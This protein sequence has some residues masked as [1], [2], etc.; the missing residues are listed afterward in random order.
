[1]NGTIRSA[2]A[3]VVAGGLCIGLA[4]P[5][6]AA[7]PSP[8]MPTDFPKPLEIVAVDRLEWLG[9]DLDHNDFI[10]ASRDDEVSPG[11]YDYVDAT[12][13]LF[14]FYG[15]DLAGPYTVRT[16]VCPFMVAHGLT[17]LGTGVVEHPD[18]PT[19]LIDECNAAGGN[20]TAEAVIAASPAP[21]DSPDPAG[22]SGGVGDGVGSDSGTVGSEDDPIAMEIAI[23]LIL[24]VLGIGGVKVLGVALGVGPLANRPPSPLDEGAP[25]SSLDGA[26]GPMVQAPAQQPGQGQ[27]QA[28]PCS[29]ELTALEGI[30]AHAR[31]LNSVLAGL[32]DFAAQLDQ[33]VVLVEKAAI[34][35]EVGVEAAFL[36]GGAIGGAMGPGWIPDILLGKIVEGVA[37]DQLKGLI[38]TSLANAAVQAPTA[39][40]AG[41]DARDEAAQSTLKGML[42][43]AV[44]NHYLHESIKGYHTSAS[45]L[46]NSLPGKF[47]AADRIG[48]HM[49]EAVGNLITLYGTGMNVATLVQ[50]S[51]ILRR[52]LATILDDIARVE[53]EFGTATERM[54]SLAQDLQRCRWVHS[55]TK[56]PLR[57]GADPARR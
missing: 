11:N 3:L 47:E 49:A 24:F 36:G 37:K 42:E 23:A 19:V 17:A 22:V 20:A 31:G 54:S 7:D 43:E 13:G 4:G 46:A 57:P 52:Q 48:G 38:K 50:Q 18:I 55:A 12:G 26:P 28:D 5:V 21:A 14:H 16:D 39:A 35:A 2:A 25:T 56:E 41:G 1:M 44:S 45:A 32:R 8:T 10:L 30:S 40:A 15:H 29:S 34:P 53:L 51:A 27:A 9:D 33:Q 6:L